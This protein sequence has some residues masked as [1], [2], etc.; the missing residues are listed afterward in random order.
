[1]PAPMPPP[2]RFLLDGRTH[3]YIEPERDGPVEDVRSWLMGEYPRVH[4][5]VPLA[6]GGTVYVY[7]SATHWDRNQIHVQWYDD[8]K[9]S[10]TAWLAKADIRPVTDSEW[11]ID[12]YNRTPDWLKSTRWGYRFPG[13]LPE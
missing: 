4:A 6:A 11:D 7:A 3:E 9:A 13:F 12:Q 2:R 1:M 5:R 10:L 8:N